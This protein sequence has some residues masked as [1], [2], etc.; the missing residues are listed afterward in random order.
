M[1]NHHH[2]NS[3]VSGSDIVSLLSKF[4]SQNSNNASRL[5]VPIL[6]E[7]KYR[8][9]VSNLEKSKKK[10]KNS[11]TDSD[12]DNNSNEE[13]NND[14]SYSKKSQSN[15]SKIKKHS[16]NNELS[17]N[18]SQKHNDLNKKPKYASSSN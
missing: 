17:Y 11:Y 13:S 7:N 8:R 6:N 3:E 5:S 4:M 18:K 15:R 14:L 9:R 10:K 2:S 1:G 16:Y 12:S